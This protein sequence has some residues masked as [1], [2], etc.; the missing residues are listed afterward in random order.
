MKMVG[1]KILLGAV[2]ISC[3]V[4]AGP[5]WAG[6]LNFNG[7]STGE[8]ELNFNPGV[9]NTLTIGSDGTYNGALIT[10]LL[11]TYGLCGGSCAISSGYLM[12]TSGAEIS[13]G[14]GTY[15][16]GAGGTIDVYGGIA[17]LGIANGTLLMSATFSSGSTL[18]A[19]GSTGVFSGNLNL[20]SITLN[21]ALGTYNY[22]GGSTAAITV[23]LS[24]SCGGGGPCHGLITTAG[25]SMQTTPEPA[26]LSLLGTGLL[27]VG[28]VL[29]KKLF[30]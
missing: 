7:S 24:G 2:L 14:S 18:V 19:A 11:N 16:F 26:S 27:V 6:T 23:D 28:G 5:A 29:R 21:S 8:G 3:I 20:A 10:Q 12:L 4:F 9:G 25:V 22:S 13:G 30:S 17:S 1:L 15:T